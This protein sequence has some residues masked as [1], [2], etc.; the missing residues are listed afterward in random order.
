MVSDPSTGG[1]AASQAPTS[2]HKLIGTLNVL[3]AGVMLLC[4]VC[5]GVGVLAQVAMAPLSEGYQKTMQEAMNTKAEQERDK[6]IEALKEEEA[7]AAI[8]EEKAELAAKRQA[9]EDQPAPEFPLADMTS[10]YHDSLLIR[11][12]I[13]DAAT[14]V[15]LNALL[16]ASGIGLLAARSW[17]RTLGVWVAALKIVRLVAIYGFLIAVVAPDVSEK[18]GH[19]MEKVMAQV[20]QQQQAA[21]APPMPQVGQTFA[22]FYGIAMSAG[23]VLMIL[24][25]SIYP[26][27][28]LW[29]LT[30]PK[31]KMACGETVPVPTAESP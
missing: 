17:G 11:Y 8:D 6:K 4:G 14:G 27:I 16:F 9:L 31:V 7:A 21:G 25:G 5:S 29:V 24:F 18:M 23:G 19:M 15:L 28:M 10:F 26:I 12:G 22:A 3:F 13:T 20:Q 2:A 1:Y 30:R